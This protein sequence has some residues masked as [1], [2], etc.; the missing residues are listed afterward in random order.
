MKPHSTGI[1][2]VLERSGSM[3]SL[4]ADRKAAAERYPPS[5]QAAQP[6]QPAKPAA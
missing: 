3:A 5:A 4:R 2:L 1:R 6:A